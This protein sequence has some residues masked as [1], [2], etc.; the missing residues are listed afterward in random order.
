MTAQQPRP[1]PTYASLNGST[2]RSEPATEAAPVDPET[3]RLA[4]E[5]ERLG[6]LKGALWASFQADPTS[7][8]RAP[9]VDV[10][11]AYT[12][13]L[14]LELKLRAAGKQT[15]ADAQARRAMTRAGFKTS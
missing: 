11:V 13:A 10:T 5:T 8:V 3:S 7:A 9:I 1:P 4:S 12:D 14:R 6:A 2:S 15:K